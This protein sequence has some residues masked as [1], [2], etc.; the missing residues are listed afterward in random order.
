MN[1][2]GLPEALG[3][4]G[5]TELCFSKSLQPLRRVFFNSFKKLGDHQLLSGYPG[6][7]RLILLEK[8]PLPPSQIPRP[9]GSFGGGV[10]C[11]VCVC[12][13]VAGGGERAGGR[14]Q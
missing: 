10:V 12:V 4:F 14:R 3:G 7:R 6:D 2:E 1:P 5:G 11:V 13:C 8:P 9:F